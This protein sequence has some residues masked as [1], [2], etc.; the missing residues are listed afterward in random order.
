MLNYALDATMLFFIEIIEANLQRGDTLEE[1]ARNIS[2]LKRSRPFIYICLYSSFFFVAVYALYYDIF[3]A[4]I[5]TILALK[6][7][8]WYAKF[9]LLGAAKEG[10]DLAFANINAADIKI[11][12]AV[13]YAGAFFYAFLF[14]IA[15]S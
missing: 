3:N 7:A 10:G 1:Y 12:P 8:D 13:R 15:I 14:Y 11:T 2:D 6:F 9:Y 5:I 4:L